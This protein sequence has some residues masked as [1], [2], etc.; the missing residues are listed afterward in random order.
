MW[1][2]EE[3]D[4]AQANQHRIQFQDV[5]ALQLPTATVSTPD[6]QAIPL[7]GNTSF[8]TE[9]NALMHSTIPDVTLGIFSQLLI[10]GGV[11]ATHTKK[12]N[13]MHSPPWF[14]L[15]LSDGRTIEYTDDLDEQRRTALTIGQHLIQHYYG[16]QAEPEKPELFSPLMYIKS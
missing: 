10:P 15:Q 4:F 5:N 16:M 8:V 2:Q 7:L 14:S 6:G 1:S 12:P 9:E 11:L 13:Y 3:L